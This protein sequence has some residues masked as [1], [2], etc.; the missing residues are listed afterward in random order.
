MLLSNPATACMHAPRSPSC[1]HPAAASHAQYSTAPGACEGC[2][3][4]GPWPGWPHSAPQCR[5]PAERNLTYCFGMA[6]GG[7]ELRLDRVHVHACSAQRPLC[8]TIAA[9]ACFSCVRD[10]CGHAMAAA[11]CASER[12]TN[13]Q[14]PAP[15]L[16]SST[17]FF[18][19]QE[20]NERKIQKTSLASS[21]I[22]FSSMGF[23]PR[24]TAEQVT[25]TLQAHGQVCQAVS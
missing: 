16:A 6:W 11:R 14:T 12:C 18:K 22:F 4:W 21:T 7:W 25:S 2:W 17:I 10:R 3:H 20:T 15:Q 23:A 9:P 24:R 13:T 1:E 5:A 19:R 8:S